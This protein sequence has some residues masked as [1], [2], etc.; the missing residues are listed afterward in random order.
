MFI[1]AN[2]AGTILYEP[3]LPVASDKIRQL[4]TFQDTQ[5]IYA[6]TDYPLN[7]Q[8]RIAMHSTLRVSCASVLYRRVPSTA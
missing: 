1:S 4:R 8:F 5:A 6:R 7:L 3:R 2:S